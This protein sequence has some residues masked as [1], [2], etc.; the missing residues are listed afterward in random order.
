MQRESRHPRLSLVQVVPACSECAGRSYEERHV[1]G[2]GWAGLV[3]KAAYVL[4]SVG[5]HASLSGRP[6]SAGWCPGAAGRG[7]PVALLSDEDALTLID[8]PGAASTSDLHLTRSSS[9]H[10]LWL[11][12][13]PFSGSP[14]ASH[15]HQKTTEPQPVGLGLRVMGSCGWTRTSNRPINSRMLCH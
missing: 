15:P 7:A 3:N 13:C 10:G 4:V 14:P 11:R 8:E 9:T 5:H 1:S 2:D 6:A 12:E